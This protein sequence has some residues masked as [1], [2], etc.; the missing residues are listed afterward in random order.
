MTVMRFANIPFAHLPNIPC[1]YSI[2]NVVTN[3]FYIG[4]TQHLA[5]RWQSHYF[6]L[7]GNRHHNVNLQAAWNQHGQDNFDVRVLEN[8]DD[9]DQLRAREVFW[10][11]ESNILTNPLAY[12]D[13]LP[14]VRNHGAVGE[15]C[16]IFQRLNLPIPTP[17]KEAATL[18]DYM[19]IKLNKNKSEMVEIAVLAYARHVFG[20]LK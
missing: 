19:A 10:M 17:G 6:E 9:K 16:E 12:N 3:G 5:Q 18:L 11:T 1:V 7:Q 8:V 13:H 14:H 4:S 20:D 2:V 15:I